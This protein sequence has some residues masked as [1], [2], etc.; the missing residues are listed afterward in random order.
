MVQDDNCGPCSDYL[1]DY[2]KMQ[3]GLWAAGR[4]IVLSVEGDPDVHVRSS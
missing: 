4:P 3:Q 1:T 2:G